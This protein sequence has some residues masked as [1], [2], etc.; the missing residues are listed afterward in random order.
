MHPRDKLADTAVSVLDTS[1]EV[2]FQSGR[3]FISTKDFESRINILT[4]QFWTIQLFAQFVKD[5]LNR[6]IDRGFV[7]GDLKVYSQF[8]EKTVLEGVSRNPKEL[9]KNVFF[10]TFLLNFLECLIFFEKMHVKILMCV[11]NKNNYKSDDNPYV[12]HII[13]FSCKFSKDHEL[14]VCFC[15]LH[16]LG[17]KI[18][19]IGDCTSTI[20]DKWYCSKLIT[21][22]I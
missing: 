12:K 2:N 16:P 7:Y 10:L 1:P 17:N 15:Y 11:C 21:S 22:E 8:L 6:L 9:V 5:N 19:T 13:H 4:F 3:F 20:R 18:P 14:F